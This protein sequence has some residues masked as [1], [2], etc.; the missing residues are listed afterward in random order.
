MAFSNFVSNVPSFWHWENKDAT[1][2]SKLS[3]LLGSSLDSQKCED[4]SVLMGS[5]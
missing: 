2:H 1:V 5:A 3:L 4:F